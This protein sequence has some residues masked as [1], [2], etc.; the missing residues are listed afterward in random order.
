MYARTVEESFL[1]PCADCSRIGSCFYSQAP[2]FPFR[3][4]YFK[5]RR[6]VSFRSENRHRT[7]SENT[8]GPPA[9]GDH[10]ALFRNFAQPG[11]QL[12]ER[13]RSRARN[14]ASFVLLEGPHIQHK[15]T[16]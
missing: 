7:I 1:P 10:F 9:V 13:N 3:K 14:V 11:S 2:D 15:Y 5:T 8:V 6:P 4:P 12:S 16:F